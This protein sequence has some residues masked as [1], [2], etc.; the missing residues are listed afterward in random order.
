MPKSQKITSIKIGGQ[1]GQGIKSVGLMLAKLSA[2]SGYHIYDSI[3]YPSLI[4]GGHNVMQ[5]NISPEEIGAP[6]KTSEL[7]IALNQDTINKHH[8][9]LF[10]GAFILFDSNS[11]FDT[12]KINPA[13][14]LIKIPLAKIASDAGGKDLYANI[15]A[16]GATIAL[17][18]GN[19]E[20]LK[21]L[22]EEEFGDK[23]S[24]VVETN[25]KVADEGYKFIHENYAN[26]IRDDLKPVETLSNFVPN[27]VVTGAEA[28]ALGS[29]AAGIQF[30]AIYPMSP[31]SNVLTVLAANQEKFG[32][33]CKQAEDE[34]SA[35]NMSIGA[36][37]AGARS[38]TSTSGGGFCLMTEG[39]GL[40]G[41]TE[42]PLVIF[43]GMRGGPATGLPT[44][45]EQSDLHMA[46]H[47]HQG[48]FPRIVLAP[49]DAKESFE[50]T[51][52]AFNLADKYQTTV[53]ILIDKIIAENDQ[54]YT[55]FDTTNYKINRGKLTLTKDENY[56]RY[57]LEEDGISTRSIPGVGNFF[58]ANSDE[59]VETGYS[60]EEINDR[61]AMMEKRMKKLETCE[62]EDMKGPELIG[63]KDADIT[64]V[65][66][67]SNK[68]SILR[69]M[70]DFDNVNYLHI[71]WMNPFP[72]KEVTEILSKAKHI[73]DIEANYTGHLAALIREKTGID[74]KDKL[75]QYDGRHIY[76]EDISVKIASVLKGALK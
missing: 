9:E 51:M 68:G 22:I 65:S 2:R 75:L 62:K 59:H 52:E 74:I 69:A 28:L 10:A 16:L 13:I 73:I 76:P 71:T 57:K 29:I 50:L 43:D 70:E 19:L 7:L 72:A 12:T 42:T 8:E 63:P 4:R 67:G 54:S 36:S 35:I 24:T 15:V 14:N 33:I 61:N 18:S 23:G 17:F 5:I 56:K 49:A 47:S 58:V 1:A 6:R 21:K 11:N 27:M 55:L 26:I 66:W 45:S 44:W 30:A 32:Y 48:D 39:Y 64:L 41:M 46:L 31:V 37:F 53:M 34:I 20:I 40:A 60:T 25:K 38:V 3:E